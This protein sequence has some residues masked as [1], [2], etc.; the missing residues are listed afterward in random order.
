MERELIERFRKIV[1]AA[2]AITDQALIA[3]YLL[4]ERGLFHGRTPLLLRPASTVEVSSIMKLAS[5][6]RTPI[7]P[8]GGNTGLVGGQQP[9]KNGC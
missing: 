7:V 1:G 3:P 2:H 5:Q 4:E 6:T 9:D 8:Q